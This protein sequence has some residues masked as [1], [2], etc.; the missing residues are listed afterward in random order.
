MKSM[1]GFGRASHSSSELEL[2]VTLKCV[3]GRFLETRFHMPREYGSFEAEFK[4]L[5]GERILR[6]TVDIYVARRPGPDSEAF[7][8]QVHTPL[9]KKWLKAYQSLAKELK[10]KTGPDFEIIA[11]SPD[12]LTLHEK[13]EVPEREHKL[14]VRL[15]GEA[16]QAC[17]EERGREGR[18]L[19]KTLN[20]L[21]EN[22]SSLVE[23]M[24]GLRAAANQELERKFRERLDRLG[25]DAAV[26]PQRLAQEII[27]Q[28]DRADIAEEISRLKEHLRAYIELVKGKDSQ[29]KKLDFYAQELL[30][31]V[32]TIGSKSHVSALT[33]VVV[34][35]KAVVE[36]IREQVQNA[37]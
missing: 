1:T 22:L 6:G 19:Q 29:G 15:L 36:R 14:A 16:V 2:D 28:I 12:V 11:K 33:N 3:N 7:D 13:A 26:D 27:I 35:A 24:E 9:A 37:E 21:L 23:K 32:N 17:D 8:V 4:R 31:E 34:D 18:S 5:I 30:R 10:L 20:Q 25:M